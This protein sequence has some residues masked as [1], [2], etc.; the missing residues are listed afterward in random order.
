[1]SPRSSRSHCTLVPAASMTASMPHVTRPSWRHAT[2]GNVPRATALVERAGGRVAEHDVEHAAGAER[3]LGVARAHAALADERRLL[4]AERARRSAARR[5][6]RSPRRRRRRSRRSVGIIDARDAEHVE[7]RLV[8]AATAS[9]DWRPV[10]R[11][12]GRVGDVHRAA[13]Q[14]PR[15]PRVD[16]AEAQVAAALG[17]GAG[18]AATAAWSPTGSGADAHA[19][20]R[21]ARGTRRSCGGPASRCPGPT[22]SPVARSHTTVEPRWLE[23]PTASTGPAVVRARRV[24]ARGT[25]RPARRVE[26][27]EAVGGGVGQQLAFDVLDARRPSASTTAARTLLVPTSTTSTSRALGCA[28]GQADCAERAGAG[29]ACRG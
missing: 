11:G 21:A 6:A 22:G 19:L 3:D 28:H 29:R 7:H 10:T 25:C 16:G 20:A 15:D 26:L 5:A 4:V 2:I 14:R 18:R 1:M 8:P 17:V 23:M 12:V 13:R 9:C 24:R 27:D